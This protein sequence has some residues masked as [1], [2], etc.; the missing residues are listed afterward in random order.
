MYIIHNFFCVFDI[1]IVLSREGVHCG[2]E[3]QRGTGSWLDVVLGG[4]RGWLPGLSVVARE[5]EGQVHKLLPVG[6]GL[7]ENAGVGTGPLICG[8]TCL[9]CD[10]WVF[11]HLTMCLS[12]CL[13]VRVKKL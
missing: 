3:G 12:L 11:T 6:W 5:F 13:S 9:P 8:P 1:S 2:S 4:G 7:I 10:P